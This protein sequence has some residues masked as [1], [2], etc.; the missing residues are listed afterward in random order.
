MVRMA[1]FI[2]VFAVLL[3]L[4]AG[5]S[6]MAQSIHGQFDIEVSNP[7]VRWVGEFTPEKLSI[8]AGALFDRTYRV[9]RR[10][11][12]WSLT[13]YTI[14]VTAE[15][16]NRTG[17][18]VNLSN[19]AIEDG[20]ATNPKHNVFDVMISDDGHPD[21]YA[22]EVPAAGSVS[23]T[24]RSNTLNFGDGQ[25]YHE[26]GAAIVLV[27]VE[28]HQA[29]ATNH[30]GGYHNTSGSRANTSN[31]HRITSLPAGDYTV[32]VTVVVAEAP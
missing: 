11:Q 10:F 27:L 18:D 13:P 21:R 7:S 8:A 25:D 29:I 24:V 23:R 22:E 19:P 26:F 6:V 12:V 16:A 32:D 31:S 14:T 1:S 3:A 17:I 28:E 30:E 2:V 9:D 5:M 20:R 4:G 15:W